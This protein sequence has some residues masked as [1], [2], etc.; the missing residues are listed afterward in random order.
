MN[1]EEFIDLDTILA[2]EAI[3][4]HF[5]PIVS[6]SQKKIVG[7]E[8]LCRGHDVERQCLISPMRLIQEAHSQRKTLTLDMLFRKKVLE[9]FQPVFEKFPKTFLSL[10]V[11]ASL[12]DHTGILDILHLTKQFEI[13][14][15]NVVVEILE[16]AVHNTRAL[17]KFI[18][19]HREYGFLIALDD[20]GSGYS[21][22]DRIAMIKPDII[23][24]D[25]TLVVRKNDDYY[26][27]Q[28]L[29]SI[30]DLSR[31]IGANVITEGIE[32]EEEAVQTLQLGSDL[33]QGYYFGMP[34]LFSASNLFT[35]T[36]YRMEEVAKKFKS[37][38]LDKLNSK[39]D[40]HQRHHEL[41]SKMVVQFSKKTPKQFEVELKMILDTIDS[42]EALYVLDEAGIQITHRIERQAPKGSKLLRFKPLEKGADHFLQDY[43]YFLME[44]GREKYTFSSEPHVI[45]KN[46][47]YS[48]IS[49]VFFDKHDRKYILCMD[50]LAII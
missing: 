2:T 16:S 48:T 5:Q 45:G 34:E 4:V 35:K 30:V 6:I 1:T 14:P 27:E 47:W 24:I 42:I 36:E 33:L 50:V 10:N 23:K 39:R 8:G 19:D 38:L 37:S 44:S 41:I 3:E 22:L 26:K 40:H 18:T 12:I 31:K 21:N 29:K 15:E 13:P 7:Y 25:Q 11:E 43:Y 9:A 28:V 49:S 46:Q 32:T 17:K 20:I